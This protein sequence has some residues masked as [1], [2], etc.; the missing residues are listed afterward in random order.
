MNLQLVYRYILS[1][2][3]NENIFYEKRKRKTKQNK[4]KGP[5]TKEKKISNGKSRNRDHRGVKWT[6]YLLRH[7]S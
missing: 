1:L 3:K 7:D 5:K 2:S 6:R 4:T